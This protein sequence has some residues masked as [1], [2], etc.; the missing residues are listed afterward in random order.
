MRMN[1]LLALEPHGPDT[2]VGAGP[3]YPWGGLY[4]GQIV[5]QALMA[6]SHSVPNEFTV[7]SLHAYFIRRGDASAPIRFE[8]DRIRDGRSFYTRRVVARQSTGAILNM[9]ASFQL[10]EESPVAQ[11]QTCP[12]APAPDTLKPDS[13]SPVF[14]RREVPGTPGRGAAWFRMLHEVGDSPVRHAC[15]LAYASDDMPMDAV[16]AVH[17]ERPVSTKE[18]WAT[19]LDHAIWFHRPV[20]AEQWHLYDFAV[21]SLGNARGLTLGHIFD[22]EGLHIATVAQELLVRRRREKSGLTGAPPAGGASV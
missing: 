3:S 12:V 18:F 4:G 21:H 13:W 9:S 5:A 16:I 10:H 6:A 2:W 8:V 20:H 15:A 22:S 7:H 11:T 1:D 14:D 19:S 17:P